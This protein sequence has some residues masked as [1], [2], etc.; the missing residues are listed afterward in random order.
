MLTS[1]TSAYSAPILVFL[2]LPAV[3]YERFI[4]PCAVLPKLLQV[5]PASWVTCCLLAIGRRKV[6]CFDWMKNVLVKHP[7]PACVPASISTPAAAAVAGFESRGVAVRQQSD[8]AVSLNNLSH[9]HAGYKM[10]EKLRWGSFTL[11]VLVSAGCAAA[12]V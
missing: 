11:L 10:Q 7:V 8:H 12:A 6:I 3:I 5:V 4:A 2:D 1:N 9:N